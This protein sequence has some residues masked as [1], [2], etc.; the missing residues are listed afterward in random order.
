M[1][2]K[3][4]LDHSGS[5]HRLRLSFVWVLLGGIEKRKEAIKGELAARELIS[6]AGRVLSVRSEPKRNPAQAI[7]HGESLDLIKSHPTGLQILPVIALLQ[8]EE[9]LYLQSNPK[10]FVTEQKLS[11]KE[12]GKLFHYHKI[13]P[14][15]SMVFYHY[16]E[17]KTP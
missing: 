4:P 15:R 17:G 8:S 9:F 10:F 7:I 6:F 14:T 12:L 13:K 16:E 1:P 2:V 5:P 3:P 11:E